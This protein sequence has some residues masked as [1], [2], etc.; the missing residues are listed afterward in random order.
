[1]TTTQALRPARAPGHPVGGAF[2]CVA[3]PPWDKPAYVWV[4]QR[5]EP[6]GGFMLFPPTPFVSREGM[7][8]GRGGG[9]PVQAWLGRKKA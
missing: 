6:E 9:P 2:V 4:G 1:M 5:P 3:P 7:P 8:N